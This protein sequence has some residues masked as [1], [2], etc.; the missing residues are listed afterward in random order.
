MCLHNVY[1]GPPPGWVTNKESASLLFDG[2]D[3]MQMFEKELTHGGH[4]K[5]FSVTEAGPEGWDVRVEQDSRVVRE[6]RYTDWHRVERAMLSMDRQVSQ[7]E[8]SGW[9]KTDRY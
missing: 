9:Q 8:E 6:K 7:L 2:G 4:T 1:T 3:S 5:R